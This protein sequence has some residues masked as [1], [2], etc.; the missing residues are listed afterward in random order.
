MPFT[1]AYDVAPRP[2]AQ[3]LLRNAK[4]SKRNESAHG[5][6]VDAETALVVDVQRE[7]ALSVLVVDEHRR[8]LALHRVEPGEQ[9]AP[10]LIRCAPRWF[11]TWRITRFITRSS[12]SR[13]FVAYLLRAR[14]PMLKSSPFCSQN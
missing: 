7:V 12:V 4:I 8:D 1:A 5:P 10:R 3:V 6:H 11:F 2:A 14:R 9:H 13:P